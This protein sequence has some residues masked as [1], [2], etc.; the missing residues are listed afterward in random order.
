MALHLRAHVIEDGGQLKAGEGA[1]NA[2]AVEQGRRAEPLSFGPLRQAIQVEAVGAVGRHHRFPA[3]QKRGAEGQRQLG[4][5]R[6][7]SNRGPQRRSPQQAPVGVVAHSDVLG[8]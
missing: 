1:G 6:S 3:Y 4:G 8:W 2:Q 5:H 7:A